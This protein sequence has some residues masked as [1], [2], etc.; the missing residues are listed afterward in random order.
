[1]KNIQ[2][3]KDNL[4]CF[5]KISANN[6][7][8][9][10]ILLL[11]GLALI[12]RIHHLDYESLWMD[13]LLQVSFY[14]YSFIQIIHGAAFQS[15]PPL[16]YWIGHLVQFISIG[17]FAVRLPSA[18]FGAGWQV[19]LMLL[20]ARTTSWPIGF[21][22]GLISAL[23]PFNLYYS[24]EARPYAIAIFF[25]LCQLW[26]LQNLLKSKDGRNLI[27]IGILLF[28][29]TM[30]LNTRSLYPLVV[31]T[32]ILMI[33]AIWFLLLVKKEG[34]VLSENKRLLLWSGLALIAGIIAYIPSLIFILSKS[35]R[36]VA[37]TSS[38]LNLKS[39]IQVVLNFDLSPIWRA[40]VV[41]SEPLTY[42]L[43]LLVCISPFA[44]RHSELH[45]K[46]SMASIIC[47]LLPLAALLNL[48]IFQS[49]SGMPLR[50]AYVSY[51]LPLS[52]YLGAVSAHC[53]WT[54]VKKLKFAL[55]I[56]TGLVALAILLGIQTV[57]S[58]WQYKSMPRKTDWRQVSEFIAEQLGHDH[59]IIFDS[60]AHYGAWEPTFKRF[61]S[62]YHGLSGLTS[63]AQLPLLA[64]KMPGLQYI[65][66][67]MLFQWRE[68]Y[69]TPQ[70]LY[71]IMSVP[72][73]DMKAIDYQRLCRDP[74]LICKEFTGFSIIQ[75]KEPSGN[76]ARDSYT[77]IE[78]LLLEIPEG[79]WLVELHL[80]AASL[81]HATQLDG[82]EDHLN[83]AEELTNES[84][85]PQVT[86][87]VNLIRAIK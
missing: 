12:L 22:F 10:S 35:I 71:P 58:A 81:A 21:C 49:K 47:G 33:L 23:L 26:A 41:Q 83:H 18:I 5:A 84:N 7:K 29:T 38:G 69:L 55:V 3:L 80:A 25:F 39:L 28:F 73:A 9:I 52:L 24:Q 79:S 50:P 13:E 6:Y 51:I 48:F 76:L 86:K 61:T 63:M 32:S 70:S 14:P 19:L 53:L 4:N 44:L 1:M 54:F 77:I 30:F 36:Y 37:D 62:Y 66:V 43:L 15:Q 34:I 46:H 68:Y 11:I 20:I 64:H 67:I 87:M 2:N 42:P 8:I 45:R 40:Y 74:M 65:P 72:R 60:L 75:L 85:R 56:R 59:L 82:W 57:N 27:R 16:D 17:D 31:T 78:R